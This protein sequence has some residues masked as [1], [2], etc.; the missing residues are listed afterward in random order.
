MEPK[1][2]SSEIEQM[3]SDVSIYTDDLMSEIRYFREQLEMLQHQVEDSLSE[4]PD[5]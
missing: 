3:S 5:V 2:N 4:I 1:M